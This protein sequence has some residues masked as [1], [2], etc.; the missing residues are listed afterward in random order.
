MTSYSC[1][2]TLLQDLIAQGLLEPPKPKVKISNMMRVLGENAVMDP[3][4]IESEVRQQ[5]QERQQ[6][7]H[8][9]AAKRCPCQ[10]S[11]CA[12]QP[13]KSGRRCRGHDTAPQ[14]TDGLTGQH[15]LVPSGNHCLHPCCGGTHPSVSE[16]MWQAVG[17]Q[18]TALRLACLMSCVV[19]FDRRMRTGIW[20]A[21]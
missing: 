17:R 11:W 1:A 19:P 5:M 3:T 4:A 20:H 14:Q 10:S 12:W 6:V 2:P 7:S 8:G 16:L 9:S 18:G 15:V 21:S 13:S